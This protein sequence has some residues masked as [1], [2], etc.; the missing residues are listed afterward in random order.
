MVATHRLIHRSTHLWDKSDVPVSSLHSPPQHTVSIR[1]D[2][3]K[4]VYWTKVL[5]NTLVSTRVEKST[6]PQQ[7]LRID[8]DEKSFRP[9]PD[10][11]V[12]S[13]PLSNCFD[14]VISGLI[15]WELH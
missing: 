13:T 14:A 4:R 3:R 9:S 1:P 15:R 11:N 2:R 7:L 8:C 10:T 12:S 5:A 6:Y